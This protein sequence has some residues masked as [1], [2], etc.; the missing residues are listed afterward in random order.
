MG[1][2]FGY[3][4]AIVAIDCLVVSFELAMAL[5]CLVV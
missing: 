5:D 1:L 3:L 4:V 2:D